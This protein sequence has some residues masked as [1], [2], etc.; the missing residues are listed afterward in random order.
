MKSTCQY[1]VIGAGAAGSAVAWRLAEQG[2]EVT[3]LEQGGWVAPESSP[4]LTL[5]WERARHRTHHPN[6]NIRRNSWDYPIDDSD[7]DISPMLYNA[8]GGSTIHWGAHF[9]RLKPEDFRVKS[10]DGVGEDWPLSYFDLEPYFEINDQMMGV[11]GQDGDPA[12]PP[13]PHRTMPA[14]PMGAGAEKIAAAYD[15]LNYHWWPVDAAILTADRGARLACNNCG[16]CDLGCPRKSRASTDVTYWSD[17]HSSKIR[18]ITEARVSKINSEPGRVTG[19]TYLD[20]QG[21]THEIVAD[22]V[23]LA[24]NGVGTARL[25]LLSSAEWC[26]S[27]L[28]NSSDQVGR[29]LMFHPTALVTG[30]FSEAVDGFKGPF[31]CSIYSQEFY[32]TDPSRGFV[33]GFQGQTIRSDGP[34]G[35]ALGT[36]TSPVKW[37][38]QH[39]ED[40]YSQF[41]HTASITV[42]SEDLPEAHNRVTLSPTLKDQFGIPAPKITYRV[43]ENSRKILDFGIEINKAVLQEAGA[44]DIRVVDLVTSAGFHLLGTTRMGSDPQTSVVDQF[45]KA[46]DCENLFIVDGGVFVTVGALNPTSTIQAIALRAADAMLGAPLLKVAE[47]E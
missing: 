27:G 35:S 39:H 18:L 8:V 38:S 15:R 47:N 41:G 28:A 2:A 13:K 19:V 21:I 46:H 7:S 31:A 44:T 43:S 5:G 45:G 9:P 34:L 11:A 1:L 36:Y 25:L 26:P 10:L 29:N 37:G 32:K 20:A 16:P 30:I 23:V 6:P 12:Y 42:T 22:N 4:S 24:G 3:V 33:R 14:L 40:F 17:L